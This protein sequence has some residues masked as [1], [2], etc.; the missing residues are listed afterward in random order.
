MRVMRHR[1]IGGALLAAVA[2]LAGPS[3]GLA[4]DITGT[5]PFTDGSGGGFQ[6]PSNAA[7]PLHLPTGK[8]GDAGFYSAAE[9][10]M[11][12]QTRAIGNQTV[13]RRGFFDINGLITG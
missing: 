12:R 9:F 6:A 8:A 1:Y 10:V 11:L 7:V 5:A 4:Q 13:A 2:L 3:V